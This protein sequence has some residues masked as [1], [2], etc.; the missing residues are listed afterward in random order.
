[1]EREKYEFIIA[2]KDGEIEELRSEIE[3]LKQ[4][5]EVMVESFRIS[6]DLLLERLKDLETD[7]FQGERPQT[8]QVLGRIQRHEQAMKRPKIMDDIPA[9]QYLNFEDGTTENTPEEVQFWANWQSNIVKSEYA[10][11]TIQCIRNSKKWK[12]CQESIP[13]DNLKQHLLEWRKPIKMIKA[14]EADDDATM[15]MMHNHGA[16]AEWILDKELGQ[17][18]LHFIAKNSSVRWLLILMGKGLVELDPID[19]EGNTPL[20]IAIK[21]GSA[22]IAKSLIEL[23]WDIEIKDKALRTP[24]MNAWLQGNYDIAKRLIDIGADLKATNPIQ[25]T[26]MTLAQKGKNTEIVF[27]LSE[28]GA[29][30][31]PGTGLT[32]SAE[33]GALK[34]KK[35]PVLKEL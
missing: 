5:N 12:T 18:P 29:P 9:P 21:S 22:I 1:M 31:R 20:Q 4:D 32:K 3:R 35:K 16:K 30:L 34:I 19:E 33:I 27:L 6:T 25:D 23:G 24:L 7:N 17:R 14:I 13:K 28:K 10:K 15:L 11:H 2:K 26:W 8:A